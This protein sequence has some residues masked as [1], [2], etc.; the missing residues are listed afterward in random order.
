V[1]LH[2]DVRSAAPLANLA[3]RSGLKI[4]AGSGA[5]DASLGR[6]FFPDN[7]RLWRFFPDMG[8]EKYPDIGWI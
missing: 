1:P 7:C 2:I 3:P 4:G 5:Y 8:P 6:G